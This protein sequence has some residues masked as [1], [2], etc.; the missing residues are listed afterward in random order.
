LDSPFKPDREGAERRFYFACNHDHAKPVPTPTSS[1]SRAR[2]IKHTDK[3]IDGSSANVLNINTW[4]LSRA[5]KAPGRGSKKASR[6]ARTTPIKWTGDSG[7][8]Q[9]K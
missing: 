8:P 9:T 1:R 5:P 6:A 2:M 7:N 4:L 3:P